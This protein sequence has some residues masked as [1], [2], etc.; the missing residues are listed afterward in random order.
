MPK[1][2]LLIR[3]TEKTGKIH[4]VTPASAGW[5]HVGFGLHRLA[6]GEA[7]GEATE[8]REAG[9]PGDPCGAGDPRHGGLLFGAQRRGG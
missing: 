7:Y 4:D 6:A 3:P 2:H 8:E 5:T 1:S 9:G